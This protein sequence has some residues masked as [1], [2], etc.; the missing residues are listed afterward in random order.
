M[1]KTTLIILNLCLVFPKIRRTFFV[2]VHIAFNPIVQDVEIVSKVPKEYFYCGII[3]NPALV[4][5][6]VYVLLFAIL[7]LCETF[8]QAIDPTISMKDVAINYIFKVFF[9]FCYSFY[10]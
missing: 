9:V 10:F 5:L 3:V 2:S 8:K 7:R 6:T 4:N 1:F